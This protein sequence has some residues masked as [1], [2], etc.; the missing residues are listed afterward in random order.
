MNIFCNNCGSGFLFWKMGMKKYNHPLYWSGMKV[1]DFI[2]FMEN[3]N[4]IDLGDYT[5]IEY[6]T[7]K[8]NGTF[9]C[10]KNS[11]RYNMPA[12]RL[13]KF[14]IDVRFGHEEFVDFEQNYINRL[15]RFNKKHKNIFILS[16]WVAQYDD[17]LLQRFCNDTKH[18]KILITENKK[19][20]KSL[21]NKKLLVINSS[22]FIEDA[23]NKNIF[24]IKK[25]IHFGIF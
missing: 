1:E 22:S 7:S 5:K 19:F 2:K 10:D 13:N 24:T 20:N 8:F 23:I 17:D 16:T 4:E 6:S 21:N 3:F 18:Y 12:I 15:E 14:N 25:F 9:V 11:R